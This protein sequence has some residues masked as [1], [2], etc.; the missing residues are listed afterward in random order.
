[1]RPRFL[2]YLEMVRPRRVAVNEEDRK[3]TI[4]RYNKRLSQLGS[5]EEALGWGNKGRSRL[6]FH[7][8]TSR[9]DLNGASVL[10]F[11]C[12]FGD[13]YRHLTDQGIAASYTGV[14]INPS[15]IEV[16]RNRYP[17]AE[18][19]SA[20]FLNTEIDRQWDYVLCSGVFNHRISDNLAFVRVAF[21][22]FRRL[23]RR[24]F[25]VNFLSDRVDF[26]L[27]HT[28]HYSPAWVIDLAFGYSN[29][30]LLR[31]DYMPFEYTV[32]V[33]YA[34]AVDAHLTVYDSFKRLV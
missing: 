15:L 12:G 22:R 17:E 11:G 20:D 26:S 5:T 32:F 27:P 29:N 23:A 25:G 30:I 7:I 28:F 8:L 9:W 14:D 2:A 31:N 13:L 19:I 4:E 10:D 3:E 16:G 6:R 18:L 21:Q 24:G 1:M 33:D 34:D